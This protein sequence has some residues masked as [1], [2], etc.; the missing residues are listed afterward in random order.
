VVV[1][2]LKQEGVAP[3]TQGKAAEMLKQ[4][5]ASKSTAMKQELADEQLSEFGFK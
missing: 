2:G 1:F 5:E 3:E 4:L